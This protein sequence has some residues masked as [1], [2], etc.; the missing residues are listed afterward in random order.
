MSDPLNDDFHDGLFRTK[1]VYQPHEG[2]LYAEKT[3]LN[4]KLILD[5]NAELRKME[6]RKID[7]TRWVACIPQI[8]LDKWRRENPELLSND[9]QIASNK[10]HQLI[11]QHPEVMVVPRCKV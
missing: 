7:W 8:M 1:V 4:E 10:L 9:Q 2:I 6:Q 5:R 3:Q 11:Q